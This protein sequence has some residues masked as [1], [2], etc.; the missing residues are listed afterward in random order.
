M[1]YRL[2][3][4]LAFM[5]GSLLFD[6]GGSAI[7][8]DGVFAEARAKQ[9]LGRVLVSRNGEFALYEWRR[10]YPWHPSNQGLPRIVAERPQ[11]LL[12]RVDAPPGVNPTEAS[13][14][15]LFPANPGATY[16]LGSLSPDGHWVSFYELD[17]DDGT[18]RVGAANISDA[19]VPRLVWFDRSPDLRHLDRP[20]AWDGSTVVYQ[21]ADGTW[22]RANVDTALAVPCVCSDIVNGVAKTDLDRVW[23]RP[24]GLDDDATQIGSSDNGEFVVY[25]IDTSKSLKL[26]IFTK[27]DIFTVFDNAR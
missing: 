10:P 21:V 24:A 11:T 22:V 19:E 9:S 8:S 5:G 13:S 18:L 2:G 7:A 25:K 17:R 1:I 23:P 4:V 20:P 26:I 15:E 27:G 6:V 3:L 14:I 12:M 16:W